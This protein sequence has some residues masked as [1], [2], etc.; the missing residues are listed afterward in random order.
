MMLVYK[1]VFTCEPRTAKLFF[2]IVKCKKIHLGMGTAISNSLMK[3]DLG[4]QNKWSEKKS[5]MKC[6]ETENSFVL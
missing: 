6:I 3:I 1:N 2:S 4:E 5:S